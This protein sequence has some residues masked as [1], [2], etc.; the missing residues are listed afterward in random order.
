MLQSSRDWIPRYFLQPCPI[1]RAGVELGGPTNMQLTHFLSRAKDDRGILQRKTKEAG[2]GSSCALHLPPEY[3]I[4]LWGSRGRVYYT[5]G[6]C[7]LAER[8][9]VCSILT[10]VGRRRAQRKHERR[11]K[12]GGGGERW[13]IEIVRVECDEELYQANVMMGKTKV[14]GLDIDVNIGCQNKEI[15]P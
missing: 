2:H 7:P 9:W 10:G 15:N 13:T 5:Q 4:M 1:S 14:N 8:Y 3:L 6:T 11:R 12:R